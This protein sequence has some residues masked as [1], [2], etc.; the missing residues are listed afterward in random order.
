MELDVLKQETK[1]RMEKTLAALDR[2]FSKLRTG[3]ASTVTRCWFS[4]PRWVCTGS[5]TTK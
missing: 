3:R 1:E 2:E 5:A 4:S